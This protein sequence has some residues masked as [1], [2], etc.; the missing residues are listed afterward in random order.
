M[1]LDADG[2]IG[3]AADEGYHCG[4]GEELREVPEAFTFEAARDWRWVDGSWV[5]DP[6]PE[7]VPETDP[8]PELESQNTL[9]T[10][11]IQALEARGEFL[12][13][14]LAEMAMQVYQ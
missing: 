11:Q 4:V 5:L 3:A 12:E 1:I 13:D 6:L 8:I 7:A 9:L 10:A 2:R 14:C